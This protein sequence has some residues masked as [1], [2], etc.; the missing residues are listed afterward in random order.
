MAAKTQQIF[1]LLQDTTISLS[2]YKHWT[3]FLKTAAWQ[4]K[5][6]FE[7]QV[8]IH[9][10]RPD[11]TA[12]AKIEVWNNSMHRW[13]NRGAKGIALLR[14]DGNRYGL[15]YVFD[16]SDTNDRY[17]REVRLWKYDERYD[18]A[19][20]ETLGNTFGDLKVDV[21]VSDAILCAAHN[22]VA[23]NKADYLH[24]LKFVKSASLLR[25]L[26]DVNL[27]L[28][29]RQTAEVSIAYMVMQRMGITQDMFDEYEFQYIRDFN[30]PETMNILGNAVSS[31]SETALRSISETIRA[32]QKREKFAQ[33]QNNVYNRDKE[34][35]HQV[36]NRERNEEN[37]RNNIQDERRLSDT[38]TDST[39]GGTQDRQIRND[40]ENIS[41]GTPS[42]PVH[43][44]FDEGRASGASGGDRQD[45]DRAG[46]ESRGQH[47]ESGGRDGD[48]EIEGSVEMD[49]FNEQ[50]SPFGRG[51]RA[52]RAGVQLSLFDISLPS[53]EEQRNMIE[54]AEQTSPAFSIPQQIIDEVLTTGGND[55]DSILKICVQYSKNKSAEDNIAFLKKEYGTG[56][57]GFQFDNS[58]VSVWWEESGMRIAYG[59]RAIGRGE[60][61]TWDRVDK[62][63]GELL[64]VG[65]FAPQEI[66]DEMK[67]FEIKTAATNFYEMYRDC[68][69]DEYPELKEYFNTEWFKGSYPDTVDN[70][71]E[72][73][74]QPEN[75]MAAIATADA[76]NVLYADDENIMRFRWYSPDKVLP[77]LQDLRLE[78][79][80]FV[81]NKTTQ[82]A[83]TFI[84]EDEI[85]KL[86][87]GSTKY[88][89]QKIETYLYFKENTDAQER[90]KFL[91][92]RYGIGGGT[93]GVFWNKHDAKGISFSRSDIFSPFA[94]VTLLWNKV[95]KRIDGLIKTGKYLTEREINEDIPR[96]QSEQEQQR[97][98]NEKYMYL[99]DMDSLSAAEKRETLPKRIQYFIDIAEDYEKG[100]FKEYGV[101]H[102]LGKTEI[103][104]AEAIRDNETR[105]KLSECMNKISKSAVDVIS[106]NCG[107]KFAE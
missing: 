96:Y 3:N 46:T 42:E 12:C 85:D 102:L 6:P 28:R 22:A 52:E 19:I 105:R 87:I 2:D 93:S 64:E 95:E 32:E 83:P 7:D 82:T 53:E 100:F 94:K 44:T 68:N 62:R 60:L 56:G 26:D 27:D 5:Y 50:L 47:G 24:E 101:E 4:Y 43:N 35:I 23:D 57:K 91:K 84:T 13:I 104:I 65:R 67:E 81:S 36:D 78:H 31:I 21:T 77:L 72:L 1:E 61:I 58:K 80:T 15:E 54:R 29:F 106:R 88:S 97:I 16:V 17:N 90:I 49:G 69:R 11:A 38:R 30:T 20:I 9:A 103:V 74:K 99:H 70:L 63:I 39:D 51:D 59:D 25:G 45:S 107:S 10:Q 73:F 41:Q 98:K 66:L 92:D 48:N 8:L 34:N 75:V 79:K 18:D 71:T 37:G 89:T 76:L 86:L 40:E 55:R 33:Q 14:E